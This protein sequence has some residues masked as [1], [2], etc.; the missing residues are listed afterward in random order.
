MSHAAEISRT[1][2][3]AFVFLVDQSSSMSDPFGGPGGAGRSKAHELADA[4]NRMLQTLVTRC[5]KGEEIRDY[6]DV[7]IVGYGQE[8][9]AVVPRERTSDL[10][11]LKISEIA[12]NP[13]RIESRK[14]KVPDGAG[15]L[16]DQTFQFPVWLDPVSANGTPM[17]GALQ[18]VQTI[19]NSWVSSHPNSYPPM[20]IHVTDG[21]SGDGDPSAVGKSI[22]DLG[23]SD[24]PVSLFNLH[25]SSSAAPA[26]VFPDSAAGLPD[27]FAQTLFEISSVLPERTRK[28]ASAEG[29]NVN[30]QSRGFAFNADLVE[31]IRFLDIGTRLSPNLR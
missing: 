23:T 8:I 16:V 18:R 6:F 5:A 31:A 14:K 26:A 13:A 21:E 2:P 25:L 28:E 7:A 10:D 1:N 4:V 17:C 27:H 11:F 22:Q 12:F 20:V 9:K 3:S 29:Y 15:G 30:A 19:L 24:G